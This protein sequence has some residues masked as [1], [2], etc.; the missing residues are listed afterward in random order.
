MVALRLLLLLLLSLLTYAIANALLP[1][2]LTSYLLCVPT[3]TRSAKAYKQTIHLSLWSSTFSCSCQLLQQ[4]RTTA[5]QLRVLNHVGTHPV[6]CSRHFHCHH[7][8][9]S[10]P[11]AV[12]QAV[13]EAGAAS[14]VWLSREGFFDSSCVTMSRN[15]LPSVISVTKPYVIWVTFL[16]HPR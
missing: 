4:G 9:A 14:V 8:G 10:V 11:A 6:L 16:V 1:C 13:P 3:P 12:P 2:A 7:E 5:L 15:A